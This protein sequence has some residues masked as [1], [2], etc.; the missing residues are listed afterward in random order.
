MHTFF[1]SQQQKA[2]NSAIR[3]NMA[4][5]FYFPDD[6]GLSGGAIAGIVIGAVAGFA[7]IIVAVVCIIKNC[8]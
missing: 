2:H 3:V 8:G 6:G 1:F 7:L 4:F 5:H